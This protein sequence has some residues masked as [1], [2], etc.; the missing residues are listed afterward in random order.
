MQC[1]L[2][3]HLITSPEQSS[4]RTSLGQIVERDRSPRNRPAPSGVAA[5]FQVNREERVVVNQ[6]TSYEAN[7]ATQTQN[8]QFVD[9]SRNA[10]LNQQFVDARRLQPNVGVDPLVHQESIDALSQEAVE[11]H[12]QILQDELRVAHQ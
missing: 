4:Q 12:H 5:M 9:E 2:N 11:R 10:Q 7:L 1:K 8:N 3:W 6:P